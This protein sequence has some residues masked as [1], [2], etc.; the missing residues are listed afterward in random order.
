MDSST[1]SDFP[2]FWW[3]LMVIGVLWIAQRIDIIN[4]NNLFGFSVP[5]EPLILLVVAIHQVVKHYK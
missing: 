1:T 3:I 2:V 4:L 5:W